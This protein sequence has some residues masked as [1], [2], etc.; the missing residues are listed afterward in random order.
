MR[1]E[2]L[3]DRWVVTPPANVAYTPAEIAQVAEA[4]RELTNALPGPTP[5][6]VLRS[7]DILPVWA[8]VPR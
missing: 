4:L 6:V 8:E 2:P 7:V 3:D 1:V 5:M